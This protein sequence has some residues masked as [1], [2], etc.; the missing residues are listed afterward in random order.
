MKARDSGMPARDYWETLLDVPRILDALRIGSAI[1]D[2]VELGCGYGTFTVPIAQRIAG[3]LHAFDIDPEMIER[4][5]ERTNAA[6]L[7][8]VRL[9]RR[10]VIAHGYGLPPGSVDAG[11]SLQH[12]AR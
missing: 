1:A 4:T 6:A 2:A 8:N 11:V 7:T 9:N 12:P 3:T 5:R 10:D